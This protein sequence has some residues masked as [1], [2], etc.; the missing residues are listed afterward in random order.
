MKIKNTQQ[1]Q[2]DFERLV[3][4]EKGGALSSQIIDSSDLA[5]KIKTLEGIVIS[6]NHGA[7]IMYGYTEKEMIGKNVD[8]LFPPNHQEELTELT[9]QVAQGKIIPRYQT[10]RIRKDGVIID[11]SLYLSPIKDENGKVIGIATIDRDITELIAANK[12]LAFQDEEKGKRSDELI[13][14]NK[15]LAF[16]NKEKEKRADELVIAN[17]ELAFQDKEKEKRSDEL[18]I[19]NKELV[20]QNDEKEK[21]AAELVIANSAAR[22]SFSSF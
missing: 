10:K 17:K 21:R 8:I 20:F 5:I 18:V 7:E 15:E 1:Q 11:I 2:A 4:F 13:I 14:A 19:A 9:N 22:F 12:E 3:D 16:Q 6:W